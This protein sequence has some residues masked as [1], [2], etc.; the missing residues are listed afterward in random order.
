MWEMYLMSL[1]STPAFT[2]SSVSWPSRSNMDSTEGM[3]MPSTTIDPMADKRSYR[4]LLLRMPTTSAKSG[5]I[6]YWVNFSEEMKI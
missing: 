1:L 3:E 6:I 2:P 5:Q 4:A